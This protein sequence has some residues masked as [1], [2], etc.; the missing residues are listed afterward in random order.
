MGPGLA[1]FWSCDP[2]PGLQRLQVRGGARAGA[3][4]QAARPG[5]ASVLRRS[6]LPLLLLLRGRPGGGGP[7]AAAS[8]GERHT[9]RCSFG[10]GPLSKT[11]PVP[12]T[13]VGPQPARGQAQAT[14]VCGARLSAGT[15]LSWRSGHRPPGVVSDGHRV[16][17]PPHERAGK[18]QGE[19][20]GDL[21][22]G[23][24]PCVRG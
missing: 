3:R 13:P 7:L 23:T 5:L 11:K 21:M 14:S 18:Q 19:D 4:T 22:Q 12:E 16:K 2:G 15:V 24:W 8:P 20:R 10:P 17:E 6:R 9:S 1:A